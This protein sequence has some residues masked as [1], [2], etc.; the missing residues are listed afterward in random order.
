MLLCEVSVLLALAVAF[1]EYV[2]TPTEMVANSRLKVEFV[3]PVAWPSTAA[4]P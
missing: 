4:N 1:T 2:I 3:V